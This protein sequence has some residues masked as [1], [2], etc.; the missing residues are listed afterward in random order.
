[1]SIERKIVLV[2][3]EIVLVRVKM[4][5]VLTGVILEGELSVFLIGT[6]C[7]YILTYIH[8]HIYTHAHMFLCMLHV[9]IYLA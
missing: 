7:T 8:L 6:V 1:M 3:V 5:E 2:R 9:R 4:A